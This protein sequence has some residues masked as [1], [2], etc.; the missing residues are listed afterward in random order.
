MNTSVVSRRKALRALCP[1][2]CSPFSVSKG[3]CERKLRND[4][5]NSVFLCPQ[6]HMLSFTLS[7][8]CSPRVLSLPPSTQ[9]LLLV[10]FCP[11]CFFT[12]DLPTTDEIS[13]SQTFEWESG[14]PSHLQE[15]M[16]E[17]LG[18]AMG[19]LYL[20]TVTVADRVN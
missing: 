11:G 20:S 6:L 8:A 19:F 14:L 4:Q 7:G 15:K 17:D 10:C 16:H 12:A 9:G 5:D 18:L 2:Q 13:S 1:L 3:C